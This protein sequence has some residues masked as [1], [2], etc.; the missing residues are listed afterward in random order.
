MRQVI[1]LLVAAL[2]AATSARAQAVIDETLPGPHAVE[3]E[4]HAGD[5][6]Q[7]FR[8]PPPAG[9]DEAL[10][11]SVAPALAARV[12]GYLPYWSS[13]NLST[14]RWDLVS[15]VL[16]FSYGLSVDGKLT[17][18]TVS[19]TVGWTIASAIAAAHA[20]GVRAHLCITRFNSTAN[21]TAVADFLGS[22]T[23]KAATV[24]AAANL[25]KQQ[26]ADG[27][28]FDLEFVP[29]TSRDAFSVFIEDA[30]ATLRQQ[31]PAGVV[32]IAA[33]ASL[34]YKG[35]D[36]GKLAQVSDGLL[37]MA[38]GYHYG[39]SGY[40]GPI[41]PLTKGGYWSAAIETDIEAMLAVA[42]ASSI[43]LGVP[44][45]G[46]DWQTTST[47]VN[48]A[49]VANTNGK[50]VLYSSVVPMV[51]SYGRLWDAP[52]QTPWL[53]YTSA[54]VIHELWYDDG[55]SLAAKYKFVRSKGL[56]G[57]MI[58]ALGYDSGRT[59]LWNAIRDE[60]G[61]VV[62]VDGGSPDAGSD[63]GPADAG[64]GGSAD[65][66]D[67]GL[68]G[69]APDAGP[70][71]AGPTDGGSPP[72]GGQPDAGQSDDGGHG[73]E[74]VVPHGGCGTTAGVAGPAIWALVAALLAFGARARNRRRQAKVGQSGL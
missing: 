49:V 69:G 36:F 9:T 10:N 47:A 67:G 71:D 70:A 48:A 24:A 55:P 63:G 53:N 27:V 29:S 31:V 3:A 19:S 64:D 38:Y 33:P 34:G 40:T 12:W 35:Y 18:P 30:R 23:A 62:V 2:L 43:A 15:D 73:T 4:Q 20:H 5:A 14:F 37:V 74:T 58:W 17:A 56:Q 51:A 60:L 13:I 72:D 54:G 50:A 7:D 65:A 25:A 66:G 46:Y 41:S 59:E 52:S 6:A 16:I 21:P 32:T 11:E 61:A 8:A 39:G 68:D 26:G 28:N 22:A 45:Y 42:P 57:A 1:A 44:Y